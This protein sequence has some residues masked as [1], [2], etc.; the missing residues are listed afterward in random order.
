MDRGNVPGGQAAV[1]LRVK[2]RALAGCNAALPES[3]ARALV[4]VN[5]AHSPDPPTQGQTSERRGPPP[6]G[7]SGARHGQTNPTANT[8]TGTQQRHRSNHRRKHKP[9]GWVPCTDWHLLWAYEH[10]AQLR[11]RAGGM[12]Q[13]RG[14]IY[15]SVCLCLFG[16]DGDGFGRFTPRQVATA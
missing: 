1:R 15:M 7:G 11:V 12:C 2:R 13:D 3:S 10:C 16:C 5:G 8:H 9:P 4:R 6:A 14:A